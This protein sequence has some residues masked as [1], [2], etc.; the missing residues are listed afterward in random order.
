MTTSWREGGD[1]APCWE[2]SQQHFRILH[3]VEGDTGEDFGVLER[4]FSPT[5][6]I[7]HVV[8]LP[9]KGRGG[10]AFVDVTWHRPDFFSSLFCSSVLSFVLAVEV[11]SLLYGK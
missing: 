3:A 2:N 9:A 5:G 6:I 7:H 1:G 11:G 4:P 8:R 10:G